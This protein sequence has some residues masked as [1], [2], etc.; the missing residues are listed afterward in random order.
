MHNRILSKNDPLVQCAEYILQHEYEDFRRGV[1]S[2]PDN[3]Q[4]LAVAGDHIYGKAYQALF[5]V[6][7]YQDM[8]I[9]VF[10]DREPHSED[11][12]SRAPEID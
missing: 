5:G 7:A 12:Y 3:P 11:F 10:C 2:A 1:L 6:R 8:V 4:A 9:D